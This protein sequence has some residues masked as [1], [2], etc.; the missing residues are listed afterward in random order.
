MSSLHPAP[1]PALQ[2][3]II[4]MDTVR[5]YIAFARATCHP[6]LTPEAANV[7]LRALPGE[8]VWA[9]NAA[10]SQS[11]R[12]SAMLICWPFCPPFHGPGQQ[13]LSQAYVEMRSMGMSRKIV[14]AT[15]R[16]LE[17]LIRLSG[18]DALAALPLWTCAEHVR[19]L[20][21]TS[22][23]KPAHRSFQPHAGRPLIPPAEALARMR[24]AGS[25]TVQDVGEAVRL[26]KVAMQQSSI[27]P[28]TGQID[29]VRRHECKAGESRADAEVWHGSLAACQWEGKL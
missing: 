3:D 23:C 17:S 15:P 8:A 24:L 5:D 16:Q 6:V 28:R 1:S 21:C 14:S 22:S 11:G 19:P 13:A 29:M 18:K 10:S 7:S 26:M 2:A 12:S 25:V 20:W 4:P 27:D 9:G